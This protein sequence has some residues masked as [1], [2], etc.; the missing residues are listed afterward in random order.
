MRKGK[1]MG[2]KQLFVIMWEVDDE[3]RRMLESEGYE[4]VMASAQ[5]TSYRRLRKAR[6]SPFAVVDLDRAGAA[7]LEIIKWTW[8]NKIS[9]M[10][11]A[12]TSDRNY[13]VASIQAGAENY[14]ARPFDT[15][16]LLMAL[17]LMEERR[18][19]QEELKPHPLLAECAKLLDENREELG[20]VPVVDLPCGMGR[21]DAPGDPEQYSF[22]GR[23]CQLGSCLHAYFFQNGFLYPLEMVVKLKRVKDA[24]DDRRMIG[25]AVRFCL[26]DWVVEKFPLKGIKAGMD[27]HQKLIRAR[28]LLRPLFQERGYLLHSWLVCNQESGMDLEVMN[29]VSEQDFSNQ[30][31]ERH[32]MALDEVFDIDDKARFSRALCVSLFFE[33]VRTKSEPEELLREIEWLKMTALSLL[34]SG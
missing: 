22:S 34:S 7:G 26:C 13:A 4:L 2:K 31:L 3:T 8:Q 14:L 10:F 24:E 15:S 20:I 9:T 12:I 18:Q 33:L 25:L 19:L 6:P 16:E 29:E 1:A 21:M 5:R 30:A 27:V 32:M 17:R 11:L 28:D 23:A